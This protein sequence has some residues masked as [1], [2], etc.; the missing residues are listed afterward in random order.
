MRIGVFGGSFDPVHYGHLLLAEQCR[1]QVGLEKVLF[2]PAGQPPHK[3]GRPLSDAR[4][5]VEMVRLAIAGFEEYEVSTIEVERPGP[6]YT[7]ETLEQ[8]HEERPGDEF[9]LLMGPDMLLDFPHWKQPT[10]IL[11]LARLAVAL[12]SEDAHPIPP[13]DVSF[14][15]LLR[16]RTTVVFMPTVKIRATDIRARV[17]T[18]RSIR[19]LVPPP[20]ECYVHEHG[21]YRQEA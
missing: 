8:L 2:I 7:V 6:S 13:T 12:Y 20:V 10:R 17:R 5:R 9:F 15:D 19:F 3:R 14:I 18:G 21:L 4:H 11:E 1:E 16:E